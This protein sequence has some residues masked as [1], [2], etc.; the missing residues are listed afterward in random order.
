MD[1]R[2]TFG[3]LLLSA[4]VGLAGVI[5]IAPPV[6]AA[7]DGV[8]QTAASVYT[9]D[10]ANRR[11]KVTVDL[12]VT[13]RVQDRVEEV[14]CQRT[15][16][17]WWGSFPYT[18]TC[19][20][21][22]R[23]YVSEASTYVENEAQNIKVSAEGAKVSVKK[24]SKGDTYRRLDLT[25]SRIWNGE[26]RQVRLTY[27]IPGG[28]PRSD[29]PTRA[30]KAYT[31]FCA[32]SHGADGGSVEIRVPK[33]F[34]L[35]ARGAPLTSAVDGKRRVYSSGP[36]DTASWQA[37]VEGANEAGYK[38]KSVA[39]PNGT[40]V[41]LKAWPEDSA[42]VKAVG[43]G[44]ETGLPAL[45]AL[46]GTDMALKEPLLVREAVTGGLYA[47]SY[48]EDTNTITV[49]EEFRQPSLVEHEL[50]HVWF[51]GSTLEGTWLIEGHAEWAARR[52][53]DAP[54][55]REPSGDRPAIAEWP[56]L[57]PSAS[58]AER[59]ALKRRYA[60][61]CWVV[62]AVAEAAGS[63]RM[64]AALA[65]LLRG[66]DPYAPGAGATAATGPSSALAGTA[67]EP[68]DWRRWLDAVDEIALHSAGAP[69]GLASDLV[70][71][72]GV[73]PD[74][75]LLDAR[76]AVRTAYHE[77]AD[78][79]AWTIPSAVR[80]PLSAWDFAAADQAI[81]AAGAAWTITGQ[82]DATLP[83]IDARGGPAAIAW[84]GAT[85]VSDLVAAEVLAQAQLDAARDVVVAMA[86]ARTPR[87]LVAEI[88]LLGT[89]VPDI[90]AAVDA[91]RDLDTAT[92]T[93]IT[94]SIRGA[95]EGA[96]GA[97]RVRIGL[98][99]AIGVVLLLAGLVAWRRGRRPSVQPV[100]AWAVEPAGSAGPAAWDDAVTQAY[101]APDPVQPLPGA[102]VEPPPGSSGEP[103]G[104]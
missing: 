43:S 44:I 83:G 70:L 56:A 62:T 92:A 54:A 33:G 47:G 12:T 73:T 48:T 45:T 88:G 72:Y 13:N 94:A 50:A 74:R 96:A 65:V 90:D 76:T 7:D 99:G 20:Q 91:V 29:T 11:I 51:N 98:A 40:E 82:T 52:V 10:T 68:A 32:T 80:A 6:A 79:V 2:R 26:S 4:V 87:D 41:V 86:V 42:W 67:A 100:T 9:L 101:M 77:L 23:Y 37:C 3:T 18:D 17:L 5:A 39:A 75:A 64:Q 78:R 59:Q 30:M 31:R 38:T 103:G 69:A 35:Q 8:T 49:D 61:S 85:T 25:F 71:E 93:R 24:R 89:P 55:C 16:D 14:R 1:L 21:T 34:E 57:T 36:I 63:A 81:D 27:T 84:S 104:G 28:K 15:W 46:I 97:G 60:A 19:R 95:I 102:A 22:V 58:D 66:V 53:S